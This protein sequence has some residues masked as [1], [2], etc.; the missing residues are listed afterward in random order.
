MLRRE[1]EFLDEVIEDYPFLLPNGESEPLDRILEMLDE[2]DIAI[3]DLFISNITDQYLEYVSTLEALDIEKAVS[4][5]YY[6][7][8]LLDL[9]VRAMLPKTEE[10]TV[11]FEEDRSRFI[12]ELSIRQILNKMKKNLETKEVKCRYFIEPEYTEEDCNYCISN[13]SL[14]ELINAY[15]QIKELET[16]RGAQ[17]VEGSK[18]IAKDRFTVLDKSKE[19]VAL[20][21]EKKEVKFSDIAK[22]DLTVSEKINAFL[23]LLE[24]LRRQFAEVEQDFICG[25]ITIRLAENAELID[26]NKLF[27]G[28]YDS[29]EFDDKKDKKTKSAESKKSSDDDNKPSDSE[30]KSN[31]EEGE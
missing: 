9:K 27:S 1:S 29:Y 11:Q 14:D 4:F 15:V 10:E 20:L 28:D 8:V 23:A 17:N 19:L 22:S 21:K 31:D 12:D 25:E 5:A 18:M 6:A 2:N 7:S 16:I 24:L 30:H 3:E 13:F 26:F